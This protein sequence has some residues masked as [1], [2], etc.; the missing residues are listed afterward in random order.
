MR[1]GYATIKR[2][3]AAQRFTASFYRRVLGLLPIQK[4]QVLTLRWLAR[5][6]ANPGGRVSVHPD[7]RRLNLVDHESD[8]TVGTHRD[9]EIRWVTVGEIQ[10]SL[11]WG[12]SVVYNV[13]E[14]NCMAKGDAARRV[15]IRDPLG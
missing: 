14:L 3:V 8:A 6:L 5:D 9:S 15:Q 11:K 1:I 2:L 10:E 12:L 4:R 13:S 7:D